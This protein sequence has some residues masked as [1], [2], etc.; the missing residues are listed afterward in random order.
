[1]SSLIEQLQSALGD[2]YR[3]ERELGGGGMSRTFLAH[4]HTLSRRVVVKV[5]APELLAGISVERFKREVLLAAGL[6]HPHVVPVLSAGD[7][8]G[9][10]WFTMPF[11]EG[12]SLRR[13]LANGAMPI[14]EAIG[15]LRDV[16]RAL[17]FAHASGI[18][19]RDIKP[20]NVLL[21]GSSA[22]VTD[23]GIAKAI[24]A[25]RTAAPGATLTVAGTAIGTPAYIAPEQAAGDPDVGHSADLYAF[26]AMAYELLTGRPPFVAD[27]PARVIA[28]HFSETPR[29]ARELRPDTPPALADLV[30]QCLAKEPSQ[31]PASASVLVHTLGSI[32]T[33]DVVQAPAVLSA[34][35]VHL[36]KAL[37]LW[38]AA[39]VVVIATA[40]AATR[41]IG[42]PDWGIPGAVGVML[43]GL[44]AVLGTWYVQR[45]TRRAYTTPA[46][47]P[48]GSTVTASGGTLATLAVRAG[49]HV[50]WRR[51]WTG[52]VISVG[53]FALLL[54]GFMILRALGIGPA[55][56]LRGAGEF[57]EREMVLV[58]DFKPPSQDSSLGVTVAEAIRTDLAQS[59][60]L[61]V[62]TR[63]AIGEVLTMMGRPTAS[64][65]EF[66][67]A[68]E[69][70]TREGA[71]AV[72]D[73]NIV[74]LGPSYVVSARLVSALD[75]RELALFRR[76]A[77]S[78]AELIGAIG[79]LSRDVRDKVGESLRDL[80]DTESLER[81]TTS[82][83]PA[84]RKYVEASDML[85]S[86]GDPERAR[87]L[88]REAVAHDST[89]AMA[90]RRLAAS[91][92]GSGRNRSQLLEAISKAYRHRD[93]L[94]ENERLLTE[95]SY[96][97]YGPSP[98]LDR[99]I[100]SYEA[101]VARDP[102][103]SAGLN[104]AATRHFRKRNYKRAAELLERA[105]AL[106]RPF[107]GAFTN[108]I[109]AYNAMNDREGARRTYDR[110]RT[111]L[112][113][114][115]GHW[116]A[117]AAVLMH[118]GKLDSAESVARKAYESTAS[119]SERDRASYYAGGIAML[120]GRLG[121]VLRWSRLGSEAALQADRSPT[122]RLLASLDSAMVLG[123]FR[124]DSVRAR[125]LV[126]DALARIPMD[127]LPAADRPWSYLSWIARYTQDA[128]L[129]QRAHAGW[130]RDTAVVG[131]DPRLHLYYEANS[132]LARGRPADA[133]AFIRAGEQYTLDFERS[134]YAEMG[135]AFD[136]AG[137]ADSAIVYYEKFAANP[138]SDID[139]D[140]NHL[141]G[142][143]KRLA[144]LY[145][146][147]REW[148]RAAT[149]YLKFVD[150][151]READP[152]LQPVVKRAADRAAEIA[153]QRG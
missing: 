64:R 141:A 103:N 108:L 32:A 151:W 83:L 95:A 80:R 91:Y 25:S 70:A 63:S 42:L 101:L 77:A 14:G 71:K 114:H 99:A 57:G 13:R 133:I 153:R 136:R 104:N 106:P 34:P 18:V 49:P 116:V 45:A 62:I 148:D 150:L 102:L 50:S 131:G 124:G 134:H 89:F 31:R 75:G 41:T 35:Q 94:S 137:I 145:D 115:R 66:D 11:V 26:G 7:A 86:Q 144:E 138:L 72:L 68:R 85:A 74:Q 21:A 92:A 38:A 119:A 67:V 142:A 109:D 27:T 48:G 54:A 10:P 73:G 29:D 100:S 56:S 111:I 81:V 132:A 24:S 47:T 9:L 84:L 8:D 40:W 118:E 87:K 140:P 93:R 149:Y 105:T 90:W 23:F 107:G 82:S 120:R 22:T 110:F 69:I 125:R 128:E 36:G 4:E 146:A 88:L 37:A 20:D 39:S 96:Y 65:V 16:A 113:S 28:A 129:A 97:T 12:D 5:L 122:P 117:Q 15:I 1:M 61:N 3:I 112:P 59:P 98:D 52:G 6:Q 121:D 139:I 33:G 127:S 55:G 135:Y 46:V 123:L 58:A 79:K 19:H 130:A 152:E 76:T 126:R 44:P 78:D 147:K 143:Y 30:M 53:G 51:T 2:S 60:N 43:A 17:E